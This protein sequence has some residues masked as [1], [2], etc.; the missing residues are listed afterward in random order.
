MPEVIIL[1]SLSDCLSQANVILVTTPDPVFRD[2]TP[3]AVLAGRDD[4]TVIDFWRI[5]DR[6]VQVHP[7]IKYVATGRGA[8]ESV[9][10]ATLAT[11]WNSVGEPL[12]RRSYAISG[13]GDGA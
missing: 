10:V 3:E 12:D 1:D 6:S 9:T 5:C 13:S 11:M 2:L 8:N 4:V 7:A